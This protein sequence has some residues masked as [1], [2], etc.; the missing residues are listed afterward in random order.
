ML[1]HLFRCVGFGFVAAFFLVDLALPRVSLGQFQSINTADSRQTG[2]VVSGVGEVLAKPNAAEM[3]INVGGNAEIV[4]DAVVKFNDN[5]RRTLEAFNALG[6]K[7]LAVEQ[8]GMALG[9]GDTAEMMNRA[10][11]GDASANVKSKIEVTSRVKVRL[12]DIG[13]QP[14]EQVL[15]AVGKIID[16]ARDAGNDVGPTS[17]EATMS[18]RYGRQLNASLAKFVLEDFAKLREQAYEAAMQD[19]RQRAA[20]LARLS[21]GEL[22]PIEAVTEMQVSGDETMVGNVYVNEFGQ[23]AQPESRRQTPR[24]ASET[25]TDIPIRVRLQV[26]FALAQR[27]PQTAS[28]K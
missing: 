12:N 23:A 10:M 26:R 1:S 18:Y 6:L 11:R 21:D 4:G 22:G 20:R 7:N 19:A 9:R 14:P 2:I 25:F 13:S 16:A 17:A 27:A 5:L 28:H 15:E 3:E 8:R 24:I